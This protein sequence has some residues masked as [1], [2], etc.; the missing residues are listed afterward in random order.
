MTVGIYKYTDKKNGKIVYIGKDS[1]I[2]K[3]PISPEIINDL[4]SGEN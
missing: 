3:N 2:G 4:I 1:H